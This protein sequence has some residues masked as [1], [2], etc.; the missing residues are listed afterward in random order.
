MKY[1]LLLAVVLGTLWLMRTLRKPKLPPQPGATPPPAPALPEDMVS[2]TQCG[3]HLPRSEALPGRGGVF[4]SEAH[5]GA[6]ES[7]RG[8]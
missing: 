6:F 2:C 7:Q 8:N 3:M 4:C 5:R 1:I